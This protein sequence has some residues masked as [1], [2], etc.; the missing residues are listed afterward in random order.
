M[1]N[2]Q[3]NTFIS[4]ATIYFIEIKRDKFK[5]NARTL[6]IYTQSHRKYIY[7]LRKKE[8]NSFHIQIVSFIYIQI[9]LG[10]VFFYIEISP[11]FQF[12]ISLSYFAH[13]NS[14]FYCIYLS[15]SWYLSSLRL[16]CCCCFLKRIKPILLNEFIISTCS[17]K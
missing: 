7:L 4:W 17:S 8:K 10:H 2:F 13:N 6:H 5:R 3:Y 16:Y 14:I 1:C 15:V 12:I 9:H 11:Y